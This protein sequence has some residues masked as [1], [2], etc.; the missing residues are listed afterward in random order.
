MRHYLF[1]S[2]KNISSEIDPITTKMIKGCFIKQQVS[3]IFQ[4][5]NLGLR[6]LNNI[7]KIIRKYIDELAQEVKIPILQDKDTWKETQRDEVYADTMFSLKDRKKREFCLAPTSEE[8]C[9]KLIEHYIESY[10]QLPIVV[11]QIG[12]KY[13][14]ELRCRFGLAR[15]KQFIMKD[16]YSF[17]CSEQQTNEIY[18]NFYNAYCRIF[19]DLGFNAITSKSYPSEIGGKFAHEF[20]LESQLGED[21]V[22]KFRQATEINSLNDLIDHEDSTKN[23][24]EIGEIFYLDTKYSEALKAKFTDESGKEKPFIMGCYGIGVTRIMAVLF[25][26][27]KFFVRKLAP[28]KIH[29]IAINLSVAEKLYE[30]ISDITILDDRDKSFGEKL[31]DAELMMSPVRIIVGNKI[32]I[33]D[34]E[35][36]RKESFE[37]IEDSLKFLKDDLKILQFNSKKD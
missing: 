1:K 15:S 32:E 2:Q 10:K 31:I 8:Y 5:T 22:S 16:A 20:L 12:E 17:S 30:N 24:I 14:D 7:E 11:Y 18:K 34:L 36:N 3:G 29:I 35:L 4:F 25:E 9:V 6:L 19:K 26:C 28:F 27:N 23:V 33:I 21:K 13:R 37:S